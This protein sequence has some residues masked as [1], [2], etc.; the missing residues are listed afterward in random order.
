[1]MH[2]YRFQF[3]EY[4]PQEIL[5]N[6]YRKT[7][8][9]TNAINFDMNWRWNNITIISPHRIKYCTFRSTLAMCLFWYRHSY[10][11]EY[12]SC[13]NEILHDTS[14]PF[15][16]T[17]FTVSTQHLLFG[18]FEKLLLFFFFFSFSLSLR[19]SCVVFHSSCLLYVHFSSL[20]GF[21]CKAIDMPTEL[22]KAMAWMK[23]L[24][25]RSKHKTKISMDIRN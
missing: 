9:T 4:Y 13:R 15:A 10:Q 16:M 7:F 19:F 1:M 18:Y 2:K 22:V 8:W 24:N 11:L 21:S 5:E 17:V 12:T 23:W 14:N 3:S 25:Q 20:P 6:G